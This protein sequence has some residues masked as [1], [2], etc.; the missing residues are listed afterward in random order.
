MPDIHSCKSPDRNKIQEKVYTH[1]NCLE[2]FLIVIVVDD[3]LCM[4]QFSFYC[5][6]IFYFDIIVTVHCRL[7]SKL[8]G[9]VSKT[10]IHCT[11]PGRS[12]NALSY[13]KATC[14]LLDCPLCQLN[15]SEAPLYKGYLS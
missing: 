15:Y 3:E 12:G 7:F 10:A 8:Y 14:S 5:E 1:L 2:N 4:F 13:V 11:Q 9:F 6:D